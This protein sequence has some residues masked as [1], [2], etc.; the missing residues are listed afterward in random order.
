[1]VRMFCQ[2][3]KDRE[4]HMNCFSIDRK[5]FLGL[6]LFCFIFLPEAQGSAKERVAGCAEHEL[7]NLEALSKVDIRDGVD[8]HEAQLLA[9]EYLVRN[10]A[11]CVSPGISAEDWGGKWAFSPLV[12]LGAQEMG[13]KLMVD[14]V[15][16]VISMDGYPTEHS[17]EEVFLKKAR[18]KY[19]E[20]L[21][22]K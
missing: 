6:L 7:K 19:Q 1:M 12:G 2:F 9:M 21:R 15:T 18:E 14:K 20:C 3:K 13:Q 8:E 4:A 11:G 17:P 5:K 22:A 10:V 16:G